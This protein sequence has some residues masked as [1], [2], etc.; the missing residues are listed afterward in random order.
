[1]QATRLDSESMARDKKGFNYLPGGSE[2][3]SGCRP[4]AP[5]PAIT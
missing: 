5:T 3:P 1:M 2:G 4:C